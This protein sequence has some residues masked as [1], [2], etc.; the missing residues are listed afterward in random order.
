MFFTQAYYYGVMRMK[1]RWVYLLF[2]SKY[3]SVGWETGWPEFPVSRLTWFPSL[4]LLMSGFSMGR[5]SSIFGDADRMEVWWN[6]ELSGY[7]IKKLKTFST[8][9]ELK[10]RSSIIT[11]GGA[12]YG[13]S[14]FFSV[15]N[16]LLNWSAYSDTRSS[17]LCYDI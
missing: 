10:V 5:L 8:W 4:F 11:H 7:E 15:R 6:L 12:T 9:L 2:G 17:C 16:N 13:Y 14:T 3:I 1:W